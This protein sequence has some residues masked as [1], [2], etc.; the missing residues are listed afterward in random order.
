MDWSIPGG[1][2]SL[3]L[4]S[5]IH[6]PLKSAFA[7]APTTHS[8]I[9]NAVIAIMGFLIE[10]VPFDLRSLSQKAQTGTQAAQKAILIF[11][12]YFVPF[13]ISATLSSILR[14]SLSGN[15][16]PRTITPAR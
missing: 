15:Q 1:S 16:R 8:V 4:L 10:I 9:T 7:E 2:P 13:E 3:L 14:S 5:R 6:V 12:S 11:V